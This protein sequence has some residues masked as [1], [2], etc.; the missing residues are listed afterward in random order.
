MQQAQ[1]ITDDQYYIDNQMRNVNKYRK[2]FGYISVIAGVV[3]VTITVATSGLA[4][5]PLIIGSYLIANG[6]MNGLV[7]VK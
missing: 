3:L 1:D 2:F 6:L 7:D 4:T 5:I